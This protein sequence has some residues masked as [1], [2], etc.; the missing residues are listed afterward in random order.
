VTGGLRNWPS[1]LCHGDAFVR[2]SDPN[3]LPDLKDRRDR[4]SES[5]N[6]SGMILA[7]HRYREIRGCA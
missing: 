4:L 5:Q 3:R 7:E 1:G 6:G 2:K